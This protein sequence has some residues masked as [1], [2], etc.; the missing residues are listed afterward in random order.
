MRECNSECKKP[1]IPPS[2]VPLL[3][4]SSSRATCHSLRPPSP[5]LYI[6]SFSLPFISL[7]DAHVEESFASLFFHLFSPV[8]LFLP[9]HCHFSRVSLH[10]LSYVTTPSP[11]LFSRSCVRTCPGGRNIIFLPVS[12]AYFATLSACISHP[13]SSMF[14]PL[15]FMLADEEMNAHAPPCLCA[16]RGAILAGAILAEYASC[17]H[18]GCSP[19]RA[20]R[21]PSETI[22]SHTFTHVEALYLSMSPVFFSLFSSCSSPSFLALVSP[23]LFFSLSSIKRGKRSEERREMR[24]GTLKLFFQVWLLLNFRWLMRREKHDCRFMFFLFVYLIIKRGQN[25]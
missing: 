7:F 2:H 20:N 10:L 12:T 25:C 5:P 9:L 11:L 4:L 19:L 14:L 1:T 16:P 21:A 18:T 13:S 8:Y 17:V 24:N 15:L 3:S 22:T 23:S 6:L